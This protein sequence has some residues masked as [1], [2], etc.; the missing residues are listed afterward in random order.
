MGQSNTSKETSALLPDLLED[1]LIFPFWHS[2]LVLE[3]SDTHSSSSGYP[4]M[5]SSSGVAEPLNLWLDPLETYPQRIFHSI[6]GTGISLEVVTAQSL[7]IQ[8]LCYLGDPRHTSL[9]GAAS[10]SSGCFSFCMVM[11]GGDLAPLHPAS[12]RS[13]PGNGENPEDMLEQEWSMKRVVAAFIG[14][15]HFGSVLCFIQKQVDINWWI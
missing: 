1:L 6:P 3:L 15:E 14:V 12:S 10:S 5:C 4:Q 9:G 2:S 8:V 13:I 11:C 7:K